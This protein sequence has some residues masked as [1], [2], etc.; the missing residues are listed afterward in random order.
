[1]LSNTYVDESYL[2]KTGDNTDTKNMNSYI[3]I[4]QRRQCNV[5]FEFFVRF[6]TLI[7]LH[8]QSY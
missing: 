1:M 5:V 2:I 7:F 6:T 3:I 4:G 8:L